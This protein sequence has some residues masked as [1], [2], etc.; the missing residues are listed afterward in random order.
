MTDYAY[1]VESYPNVF[2]L[3]MRHIETGRRWI[4]EVSDRRNDSDA[5]CRM[6][7]D[8]SRYGCR[9]VGFNNV[10]YDYPVIHH[11]Y[12]VWQRQ[13]FFTAAD[14]FDKTKQIIG[15]NDRFGHTVWPSDEMVKQVDLYKIH[16]FDNMARST[17]LKVLEFNMRALNIGDLPFP[18]ETWLTPDQIDT[19]IE[20][21]CHDVDET[22]K[23]HH[24]TVEKI[25]FREEMSAQ[26]GV[27]MTN[28][29]DT[30]IGKKFFELELERAV[31]GSCY[32]YPSGRKEMRQTHRDIIHLRDVIFPYVRFESAPLNSVL[33]HF[34]NTSVTETNAPPEMKDVSATLDGFTFDFGM[35]GIHGSVS[36]Q[37]VRPPAGWRLIDVD[38]TS[39]YPT[40]A[41]ANR[42]FPEHLSEAFCD[43]YDDLFQRRGQHAKGTSINAALKLAL[44]GVYG[45][46]NNVYSPFYDPQYTMTIT[47]NGQLL[48]CM[49]AEQLL[50]K[51]PC[52][53][54]Q[55]NTDGMTVLV[56]DSHHAAFE[57]FC[58]WWQR[59]TLLKI[60]SVE[61]DAMWIRDVNNYIAR[62]VKGKVKR[63]GAYCFEVPGEVDWHKDHS[64]L[65]VQ[66]AAC[67]RMLDGVPVEQT[68][69]DH[70]DAMDF[71]LR[72]KVPGGSFLEL[73]DGTRLQKVTRYYIAR[74]GREM[75]K[76]MP[77]L[78]KQVRAGKTDPRRFAINKGW[79]VA[80]CDHLSRFDAANLDPAW[81]IQEANK[82]V[83][84]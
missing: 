23:F 29:N 45:D 19:L 61:Y 62:D 76:V 78:P 33:N 35:G 39:Y 32:H 38:V 40:L 21:N 81:Y 59:L 3:T 70:G 52:R 80:V 10:G 56:P 6:L 41:I 14:A 82:L 69:Y 55:I 8:L 34:R 71:M 54:V 43:I 67:A 65:I 74:D 46:S 72:Y 73:E 48:L 2:T 84:E 44:N 5:L 9:L 16:H 15:S 25:A 1:D 7:L 13:G 30:K 4:F 50:L 64:A 51:T 60:E 42:V 66:R 20:Y 75:F 11:C 27:D 47:I 12:S 68:I 17:S 26:T 49:L 22:I 18:P 24:H 63:K 36:R 58:E 79:K 57:A 77:P 83:I 37:V 28:F 31:P 53:L